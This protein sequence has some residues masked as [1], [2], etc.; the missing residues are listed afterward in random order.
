MVQPYTFRHLHR[1]CPSSSLLLRQGPLKKILGIWEDRDILTVATIKELQSRLAL[2]NPPYDIGT[3]AIAS[4]C[5]PTNTRSLTIFL[6]C[7][8]DEA[9]G[10]NCVLSSQT[11]IYSLIP[12]TLGNC[13][14]KLLENLKRMKAAERV[15]GGVNAFPGTQTAFVCVEGMCTCVL[16]GVISRCASC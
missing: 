2:A 9:K 13:P 7:V 11:A 1:T 6:M 5:C 8:C 10:H 14:D 15:A 4:P 16:S 12:V 3:C